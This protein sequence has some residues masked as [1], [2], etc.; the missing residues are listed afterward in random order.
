MQ[1]ISYCRGTF[2]EVNGLKTSTATTEVRRACFAPGSEG[3][4]LDLGRQLHAV[5]HL[6]R[7]LLLLP[8]HH[9]LGVH[10][11]QMAPVERELRL[12]DA[13]G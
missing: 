12:G 13:G 7:L 1:S 4:L 10:G 5:R 9:H 8:L 3:P 6:G 11:N 2:T